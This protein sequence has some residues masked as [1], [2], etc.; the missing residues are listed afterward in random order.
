MPS[1]EVEVR[2]VNLRGMHL[3]AAGRFRTTAARFKSKISVLREHKTVDAKSII[4]LLDIQASLGVDMVIRAE[5]EDAEQA[6]KALARLVAGSFGEA[7]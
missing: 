4:G 5:G 3:K 7:E 2:I 6:V 1:V